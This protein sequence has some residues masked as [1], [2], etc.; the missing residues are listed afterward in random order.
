MSI[1][2]NNVRENFGMK[3]KIERVKRKLSQETLAELADI[4]STTISAIERGAFL[5]NLENTIMIANVLNLSLDDLL[6]FNF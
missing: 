3:I 2:L 5:P 6:N 4:H 1:D